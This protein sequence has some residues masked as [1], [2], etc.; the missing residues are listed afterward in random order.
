MICLAAT[1]SAESQ[2]VVFGKYGYEASAELIQND[3][4][5][6]E[7][8]RFRGKVSTTEVGLM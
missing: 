7:V 1:N 4:F 3:I 8:Q 2:D 6:Y 5:S